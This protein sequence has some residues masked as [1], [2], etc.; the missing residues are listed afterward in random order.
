M[1]DIDDVQV[2]HNS[3]T[4]GQVRSF[5]ER[6]ERLNEDK[7]EITEA[8]AEV[9]SE[10]KSMG[11]DVKILRKIIAERKLSADEREEEAALMDLYRTAL[12]MLYGT[13]LGEA[14]MTTFRPD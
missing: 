9:F 8:I 2:G 1:S 14:A 4:A 3:V 7:K 11:Y 10:A 12:G 13:P 6:V 5:V